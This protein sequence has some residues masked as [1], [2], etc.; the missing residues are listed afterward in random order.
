MLLL[1]A[2]CSGPSV[3]APV[4]EQVAQTESWVLHGLQCEAQIVRTEMNVPHIYA[5]SREDAIRLLGFSTARDRYFEI[6]L[7]SRLALGTLSGLLGQDALQTDLE[8]RGM[9]MTHVAD[10]MLENL[11]ADQA[12]YFDAFAE[13][14]NNYIAL[15]ANDEIA[16]PSELEVAGGILGADHPSE[17]MDPWT[18]RDVAGMAAT[19]IY[20]LG[21]ETG[22]VGRAYTESVLPDLYAGAALED[23]RQAGVYD[24]IWRP[25]APPAVYASASGWETTDGARSS[26]LDRE[27][28][29]DAPSSMLKRASERLARRQAA[30]G[31]DWDMGFGSNVWAVDGAHSADGRALLASDGHLALEVPSLFYQVGLDT[32]LLGGGDTHQV[33]MSIPGM[34]VMAVGTNGDIAWSQ[35]QL[36]GD[37]TDWYLEELQ[38]DADGKPSA[39][40]FEDGWQD[41]QVHE[42]VFEVADV[43]LLDSVGRTE[44]W[45]RWTTYDGR[46]IAEVEGVKVDADYEAQTGESVIVLEGDFI[47][48]QDTDGDGRV[49][50]LS[51][52]YT[53]LDN[54]NV[55]LAVDNL[56]HAT[57]VHDFREATKGL[58]A[59]SQNL[60]AA[61]KYGE[62]FYTGYQ[63]VPCRD[64]LERNGDGS[65]AEGSDPSQLLDG[66]RYGGFTIQTDAEGHVVEGAG[67][68]CVVPFDVYPQAFNPPTGY[69]LNA[70]NDPGDISL[71][72]SLTN[73]PYYIGGSWIEGYRAVRIDELLADVTQTGATIDDMAVIQGDTKSAMGQ[74]FGFVLV[75]AIANARGLNEVD[76]ILTEDEQRLVDLYNSEAQALDEVHSRLVAWADAD[77]PTPSGVQTFYNDL[78]AGEEDLAV[79]TMLHNAWFGR[80]V[81]GVFG[82]EGLP[83]VWEPTGG[84]GQTRALTKIVY[85]RGADN[86]QGLSSWNED[87]YESAFFD[88]LGT[89]PVETSDEV[90]LMAMIDALAFLRSPVE[91]DSLGGFGTEDMDQWIWGYKHVARMDSILGSFLGDDGTYAALTAPFSI[92][93]YN[94][95]LE[96]GMPPT[97]PRDDLIGFPRDGDTFSIDAANNGFSQTDFDY[98]SGPVFR[99]VF[100]LGEGQIEGINIIP[101]GQSGLSNDEHFADQAALWLGNQTLPVRFHVEDV[102][103]GAQGREV[104][105]P[106]AGGD[107]CGF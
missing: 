79:A 104:Y 88:V 57:D 75:D 91:D 67:D 30:M 7:G 74:S 68:S 44:T 34:P 93:T 94:L 17:L 56:G 73:D 52:D 8:S 105:H 47:V 18:R 71:D 9:G 20:N 72:D 78:E 83:D 42:M 25:V 95:P 41:L 14:V 43:P 77:Y 96:E 37:I 54:A 98:S 62:I 85:G 19:I 3:E 84:T 97:D 31:H 23:L 35:T 33:G 26:R 39:T 64:V 69:V 24:D 80:F 51:F 59:Y 107:L 40:L 86:P 63:A 1:L 66:N 90:A 61:D 11:T 82:D 106:G 48:P 101:G 45:H 27:R 89:E 10:T 38:L 36:M 65:W 102:I 13:G 76:R 55:L 21:Y 16:P 87:T 4:I 2:A 28:H 92:T 12:L 29:I 22:D 53:G 50:A 15:V 5:H 100:A 46:W 60:V 49:S 99:M 58:V 81:S 70:N 6:E 32:Q 103:D